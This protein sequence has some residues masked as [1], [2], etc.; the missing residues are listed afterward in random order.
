[1]WIPA[2]SLLQCLGNLSWVLII[3]YIDIYDTLRLFNAIHGELNQTC[4][5]GSVLSDNKGVKTTCCRWRGELP[6]FLDKGFAWDNVF[7][8][9]LKYRS[10]F[11]LFV[12]YRFECRFVFLSLRVFV[13]I[14]PD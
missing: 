10:A 6:Y 5:S 1:M 4:L 14:S 2:E 8:H 7:N 12:D 13:L 3:R 11:E 9:L